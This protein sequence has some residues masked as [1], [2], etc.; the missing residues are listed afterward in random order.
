MESEWKIK[1]LKAISITLTMVLTLHILA[2]PVSA[3]INNSNE[4][5]E[6]IND[7]EEI[8]PIKARQIDEDVEIVELG[9]REVQ[10][11]LDRT[12]DVTFDG[13]GDQ[14]DY[15]EYRA[16]E[17]AG[18]SDT[19]GIEDVED[20]F[21]TTNE[22]ETVMLYD[23]M[24]HRAI[25]PK[26]VPHLSHMV[27]TGHMSY[28]TL[29]D[30]TTRI[31]PEYP[32][33]TCEKGHLN[34]ERERELEAEIQEKERAINEA[35]DLARGP[36][37][38]AGKTL[39][40]I[41]YHTGVTERENRTEAVEEGTEELEELKEE[42]GD[43]AP[44]NMIQSDYSI[45]HLQR[46]DTTMLF[47]HHLAKFTQ[48]LESLQS[49]DR[50]Y[51]IALG[52]SVGTG[53]A[54][55][56]QSVRGMRLAKKGVTG[57]GDGRFEIGPQGVIAK[58]DNALD[59]INAKLRAED[60]TQAQ[61]TDLMEQKKALLDL[62]GRAQKAENADELRAAIQ[63][64]DLGGVATK[65][66]GA[67]GEVATD[68]ELLAA[69]GVD[70]ENYDAA[71]NLLRAGS[72]DEWDTI[73]EGMDDQKAVRVKRILSSEGIDSFDDIGSSV[74]TVEGGDLIESLGKYD[75]YGKDLGQFMTTK[76]D[77]AQ[78]SNAI[79]RGLS[80]MG[81]GI[82]GAMVRA[83]T[84]FQNTLRVFR[85]ALAISFIPLVWGGQPKP[86]FELT[87]LSIE[88][89]P[90]RVI[91]DREAY[92][93]IA[94][95][96]DRAY[97]QD[98][99]P[100]G[101]FENMLN[102]FNFDIK[103][104]MEEDDAEIVRRKIQEDPGPGYVKVIDQETSAETYTEQ[105]VNMIY[106][107][108]R[109]DGTGERWFISSINPTMTDYQAFEHPKSYASG[110][111]KL[112]STFALIS[113]NLDIGGMTPIEEDWA[114]HEYDYLI[115][116]TPTTRTLVLGSAI[117][118]GL[119]GIAPG[120]IFTGR[121]G[122]AVL[123]GLIATYMLKGYGALAQ[124]EAERM[125]DKKYGTFVDV[126]EIYRE[127]TP[128]SMELDEL[129]GEIEDMRKWMWVTIMGNT[130]ADIASMAATSALALPT[131]VGGFITLA[132]IGFSIGNY[133][134]TREYQELRTDGLDRMKTCQETMFE[135]LAFRA[136]GTEE[137]QSEETLEQIK[138]RLG[139]TLSGIPGLESISPE[140][141]ETLENLGPQSYENIMALSGK[142]EGESLVNLLGS[143]LYQVHFDREADVKWFLEEHQ[144][145]DFCTQVDT[146]ME[147][148]PIFECIHAEGYQ[149]LDEEGRPIIDAPQTRGV[150]WDND[151][152]LM[153]VPQRVVNVKQTDGELM[154]IEKDQVRIDDSSTQEGV[155]DVIGTTHTR[156]IF[157]ELQNIK[158]EEAVIW[159]DGDTTVARFTE[160]VGDTI[161]RGQVL[162]FD[163]T[164]IQM[165]KNNEIEIQ[166]NVDN[167][168]ALDHTLELGENGFLSFT[169][170][171][172][173]P[174]MGEHELTVNNETVTRN[175]D[176]WNHIM[177]YEILSFTGER[178][179]DY[180]VEG[181]ERDEDGNII[182][183]EMDGDFPSEYQDQMDELLEEMMFSDLRG[184]E[185]RMM[186]IEDGE[187]IYVDETGEEHRYDIIGEEDGRLQLEDDR[188]L[189]FEVGP[190]GQPQAQFYQNG[191]KVGP[192]I[193]LL[194]ATGA[195]GMMGY[196]PETGQISISN[197]FP[198]QL[199][200]EFGDIGAGM[201]N[202]G[203]VVPQRSEY[204]GRPPEPDIGV[205]IEERDPGLIAELPSTPGRE[206]QI[207]EFEQFEHE[208]ELEEESSDTATT[209]PTG[210]IAL[211][212][213]I[214]TILGGVIAIRKKGKKNQG[215]IME[216]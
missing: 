53:I 32:D 209:T 30:E 58:S 190:D 90:D 106:P 196:D 11:L 151:R 27:T 31:C 37:D 74:G 101:V 118:G 23:L 77:A 131:G 50:T 20:K 211:I 175:F 67:L 72:Q 203:M 7:E 200:P 139:D 9:W 198:F 119:T 12:G 78:Q 93:E 144:N 155:Q 186:K 47:P 215:E 44:L 120:G 19:P 18:V 71:E 177:L 197:E 115:D 135:I 122:P 187:L 73:L 81:L 172:I 86:S 195:G 194:R 87:T 149:L 143:E 161:G 61:R 89:E 49:G 85:G 165:Y 114:E 214:A 16:R 26:D 38:V 82:R 208:S 180:W 167:S 56:A 129:K 121:T 69:Y 68:R 123:K 3:T 189:D 97:G 1:S 80:R 110:N 191:E 166:D 70:T 136:M 157:G 202:P 88:A 5:E 132:N 201:T 154:E 212:L 173:V 64:E 4:N 185:G 46:S 176:E 140:A 117:A 75:A 183:F 33:E 206:S 109:G 21:I 113:K 107:A 126:G 193:P 178:V 148:R 210:K 62:K 204:G 156:D 158:T 92:L 141:K 24:E 57:I 8:T 59:K 138:G 25:N 102:F 66:D 28:T 184:P 99:Y 162:R 65:G 98:F 35:V 42:L 150:R 60:L 29:L 182:G 63:G 96:T 45:S 111:N 2:L 95:F 125:Q 192:P 84:G 55:V 116:Y 171:K 142:V 108:R 128:C 133:Y 17:E 188:S 83:L 94:R 39:E 10:R 15:Q 160:P 40:D 179:D 127:G 48:F 41:A 153:T 22:G 79:G 152:E 174:G 105:P 6:P 170:G 145:I 146:T 104:I 100:A 168:P 169:N 14:D 76:I 207:E 216:K 54:S 52:I 103:E 51:S 124:E 91:E 34:P 43:V 181:V 205:P 213:F 164:H 13:F 137:G 36:L 199:N 134:F 163:N 159:H 112:F 130:G 147:G